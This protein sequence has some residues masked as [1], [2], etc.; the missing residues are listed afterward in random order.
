MNILYLIFSIILL[1]NNRTI[2]QIV[3]LLFVSTKKKKKKR[4]G[5][6]TMYCGILNII[7]F[8]TAICTLYTRVE[9][10]ISESIAYYARRYFHSVFAQCI[11]C[12]AF[13]L[14]ITFDLYMIFIQYCISHECY[15][16]YTYSNERRRRRIYDVFVFY[17]SKKPL[18]GMN[19][20]Q[21]VVFDETSGSY[22]TFGVC[23]V[24][25]FGLCRRIALSISLSLFFFFHYFHSHVYTYSICLY[26]YYTMCVRLILT[27]IILAMVGLMSIY[28]R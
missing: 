5:T 20:N 21:N 8:Y 1:S 17:Y 2:E 23:R 24:C 13:R 3:F 10:V 15:D 27:I 4:V 7:I 18:R 25:H 9:N 26:K 28:Y 12:C 11:V 19:V 14:S 16:R 6:I 22:R